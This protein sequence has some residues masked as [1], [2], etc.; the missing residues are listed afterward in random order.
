MTKRD[1]CAL[2]DEKCLFVL[3]ASILDQGEEDTCSSIMALEALSLPNWYVDCI[4]SIANSCYD[5]RKDQLHALG[6]RRLENGP[7]YH[8]PASPQDTTFSTITISSQKGHYCTD[9][10]TD[11]VDSSDDAF[12]VGAWIVE[13]SAKGRQANDSPK[14]TLVIAKK[15]VACQSGGLL[16]TFQVVC[17]KYVQT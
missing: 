1:Q 6:C 2:N 13:L 9:E 15:L 10:A 16:L 8:D 12:E 11:V 14:N 17:A 5:S 7:D 3:S 4:D